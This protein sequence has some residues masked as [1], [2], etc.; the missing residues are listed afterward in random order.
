[1]KETALNFG[2]GGRLVGVLTRPGE[3]ESVVEGRPVVIFLNAGILHHVGPNRIH[4][5]LARRLAEVGT[6]SLRLDFPG[7]GDSGT[8]G[9]GLS[10]V[11][12]AQESVTQAL[13]YLVEHGV[14]NRFI[15][16]GLCSGADAAFRIASV[17][18]RV[19]GLV[20]VDPT[21]L[22]PTRRTWAL[23]LARAAVRPGPW[24]RLLTGR[25]GLLRRLR[26]RVGTGS[27]DPRRTSSLDPQP[28]PDHAPRRD[29][30]A[31]LMTSE[32][33]ELAA[34]GLARL[35]ERGVR[36]CHII[37]GDQKELYNYRTQLLDAFPE[38]DLRSATRLELFEAAQHTFPR[39]ADRVALERVV[40]EWV[41]E[42]HFP[43]VGT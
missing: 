7:V 5:R 13:S 20:L 28:S 21:H 41:D 17:D 2:P 3:S 38:V 37:T 26:D 27:P 30:T 29:G 16:F 40:T 18:P 31:T 11:E 6:T 23:R 33:R 25:Y 36:I 1:V 10:L 42:E 9:T 35:L 15:M 32:A 14:A 34:Q 4:V 24:L 8:L 12:E 39:E 43:E 19:V 22:F